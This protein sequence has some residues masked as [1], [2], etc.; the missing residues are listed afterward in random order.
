[1]Q[2]FHLYLRE[3]ALKPRE[4]A[5]IE[6]EWGVFTPGC[7][8]NCK[9]ISLDMFRM[10]P[11]VPAAIPEGESDTTTAADSGTGKRFAS[12]ILTLCGDEKSP[13]NKPTLIFQTASDDV[14]AEPLYHED[15]NIMWQQDGR[16]DEEVFLRFLKEQFL[17]HR[18]KCCADRPALLLL[19][20]L[21]CHRSKKV[22]KLMR[23]EKVSVVYGP[24]GFAPIWQPVDQG[25]ANLFKQKLATALENFMEV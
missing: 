2:D 6:S 23:D 8:F 7:R 3:V 4:L 17:P 20:N 1:M 9:S 12:L 15:V 16:L 5:S 19:D 21:E 11:N 13:I 24:A 14:K 18:Q 22:V 25:Y 10:C